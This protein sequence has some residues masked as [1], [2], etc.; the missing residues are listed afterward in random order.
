MTREFCVLGNPIAHSR[1]PQIHELF[2]QQFEHNL[3]YRR[4][5][6]TVDRF[7]RVV[8]GLFRQ[9]LAGANVTV[10]FKVQA[11]QLV[12]RTTAEA[13]FARAVNTLIPQR[14]GGLLGA[15]TDGK[16]LLYDLKRQ[17]VDLSGCKVLLIGAGGAARGV[18]KNLLDAKPEGIWIYNR[19]TANARALSEL[20]TG[21]HCVESWSSLAAVD[22]VI[23][24]T[25]ASLFGQLPDVPE[26]MYRHAEFIYDMF[27]GAELTGFLKHV[28]QVSDARCSDGLGMLVGQAAESYRLW[29]G[30]ELPRIEPVIRVLRQQLVEPS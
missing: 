29:W 3:C 15:N 4:Q 14:D 12:T 30:S 10:P 1:S 7:S 18:L 26:R 25:S 22:V 9:G 8:A 21:V 2:A 28:Q 13:S 16:G 27:Y 17:G 6:A 23:N 19:T 5:L 11:Y 24:A 20:S